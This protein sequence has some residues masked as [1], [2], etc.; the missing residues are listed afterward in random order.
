[1]D[2][3]TS[4]ESP[5]LGNMCSFVTNSPSVLRVR[6]LSSAAVSLLASAEIESLSVLSEP[7]FPGT[8]SVIGENNAIVALSVG[9]GRSKSCPGLV[10]TI[11]SAAGSKLEELRIFG[12]ALDPGSCATLGEVICKCTVL[13][14]LEMERCGVLCSLPLFAD[15][16]K[17]S[18]LES[19]RF[20]DNHLQDEGV[21]ALVDAGLN[22]LTGLRGLTLDLTNISAEGAK[23]IAGLRRLARLQALYLFSNSLRDEGV[24]TL[25]EGFSRGTRRNCDMEKLSLRANKISP[26]AAP[27]LVQML[28]CAP[29]LRELDLSWNALASDSL[30]DAIAKCVYIE[31]LSVL[32][33]GLGPGFFVAIRSLRRLASLK[34]SRNT[35]GDQGAKAVSEMLLAGMGRIKELWMQNNDIGGLGAKSL[36]KALASSDSISSLSLSENP[37]GPSGAESVFDSLSRS[38]V[39]MRDLR[40]ECCGIG[41]LGAHAAARAISRMA[42]CKRLSLCHNGIGPRGFIAICNAEYRTAMKELDLGDN[43]AGTEGAVAIAERIIRPDRAVR[44][45]GITKIGMAAAGAK[46]VAAAIRE[47]VRTGVIREVVVAKSD[48]GAEGAKEM[49]ELSRCEAGGVLTLLGL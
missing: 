13:R 38:T 6:C 42:R 25:A 3:S 28:A 18:A 49:K 24:S 29:Q 46:A 44:I 9:D 14:T 32:N 43:P 22:K 10:R 20:S 48:C 11:Q 19:L 27:K 15:I 47:R 41:D 8:G 4:T 23:A 5:S 33:C 45:L 35:A 1:M 36:A 40:L 17:A 12:V 16:G 34:M 30:G 31:K 39:C 2:S 37:L 7:P 21:K 26:S